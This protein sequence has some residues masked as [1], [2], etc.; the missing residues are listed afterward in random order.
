[1]REQFGR[2][3]VEAQACGVPVI[4]SR[5]GAIP[6]VVGDGGWIVPERDPA[7][8]GRLLDDLAADR[9]QLRAKSISAR[10]NV[11]ISIYQRCGCRC[12][13]VGLQSSDGIQPV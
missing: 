13:C 10:L 2:V 1:M 12:A 5:S 4:G 3:I 8:L 7:N 11:E 6:A 9:T